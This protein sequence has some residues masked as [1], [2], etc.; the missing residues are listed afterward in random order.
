MNFKNIQSYSTSYAFR[1]FDCGDSDL[2]KYIRTHAKQNDSNNLSKTYICEDDDR[3]IGFV[4]LCNAQIEFNVMSAQYKEKNPK[5]PVP[6]I[7]IAR[8]AVDINQQSKGY[9]KALLWFALRK[10]LQA[11]YIVGTKF[12]V[13]DAKNKATGFYEKYGFILLADNTYILPIE[14]LIKSIA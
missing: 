10:I 3:V 12:V 8:L 5:Y 11:A 13:V 6:A 14:T 1:H 4:T 7:R 2:N 9:G